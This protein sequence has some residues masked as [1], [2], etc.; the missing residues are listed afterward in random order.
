MNL[1][2]RLKVTFGGFCHGLRSSVLTVHVRGKIRRFCLL[3]FRPEQVRRHLLRRR[4]ECAQ[5]GA[6]CSLGNACPCLAH[7]SRHCLIYRGLRPKSCCVFPIDERDLHDVEA[8]G[9]HCNF[10]FEP[11][12]KA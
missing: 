1:A 11:D 9:G 12:K 10:T 5:C 2:G 4:G 3:H 6:C 7:P 8:A